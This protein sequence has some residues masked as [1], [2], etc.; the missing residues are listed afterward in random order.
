MTKLRP[1]CIGIVLLH[2][3]GP[4]E[5]VRSG[6]DMVA[7]TARRPAPKNKAKAA[8]KMVDAIAN[9]N[10]PPEL[11]K[12]PSRLPLFPKD[13]DWDEQERVRSALAKLHEDMTVEV[14]EE[15]VR[16]S[17]DRRYSLTT[18]NKAEDPENHSVG[19]FCSSLGWWW[20]KGV[21]E[22]HLPD[23][24]NSIKEGAKIDLGME[25]HSRLADWR[26]KRKDKTLYQLQLELCEIV[27]ARLAKV[28]GISQKVRDSTRKKI[29]AEI[30]KLRRTKRP[31]FV[32]TNIAGIEL[33]DADEAKKIRKQLERKK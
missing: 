20:L 24:E 30:K 16:K 28:K 23:D 9:R 3:A 8:A 10:E 13:Y 17:D 14:W 26:K 15:L 22:Q 4:T 1:L 32:E 27:V 11:V 19:Y 31:I 18:K 2:L 6:P 33:Y 21:Y 5:E 29:E 12:T 25:N 7:E